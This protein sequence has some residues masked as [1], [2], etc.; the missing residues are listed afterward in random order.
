MGGLE[1]LIGGTAFSI[2]VAYLLLQF[3]FRWTRKLW[4]SDKASRATIDNHIDHSTKALNDLTAS[5]EKA[6]TSMQNMHEDT[7]EARRDLK[8][9]LEK[10]TEA[11]TMQVMT[12][13]S[14]VKALD[15]LTA[16]IDK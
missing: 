1:F 16:K 13:Q 12:N 10:N 14:V 2:V 6:L 4:E 9:T 3:F 8:I 7:K 11:S 5:N 15:R